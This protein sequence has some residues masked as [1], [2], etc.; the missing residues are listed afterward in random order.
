MHAIDNRRFFCGDCLSKYD[1]R[2]DKD[3]MLERERQVK[4]CYGLPGPSIHNIDNEVFFSKCIGN[5]YDP[6]VASLFSA[7]EA[8]QKGVMPFS[9]AL[10]EQPAKIIE[11][12]SVIESIKRDTQLKAQQA[13][14]AKAKRGR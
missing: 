10:F 12:F 8:Y 11:A 14:E 2:R 5:Y 6:V 1:S 4:N 9:G 13:Q 7:N 3:Q